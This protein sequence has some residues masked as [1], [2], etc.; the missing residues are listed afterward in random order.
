LDWTTQTRAWI[1]NRQSSST[2][3]GYSIGQ[4]GTWT[5]GLIQKF[6]PGIDWPRELGSK[7]AKAIRLFTNFIDII[8]KLA[9]VCYH[10]LDGWDSTTVV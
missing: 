3:R 1:Q 10:S 2:F 6:S 9:E 4:L 7:V 5:A 8:S